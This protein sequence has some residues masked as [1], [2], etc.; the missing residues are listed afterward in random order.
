MRGSLLALWP[1]LGRELWGPLARRAP[2]DFYCELYRAIVPALRQS[3][4][5]AQLADVLDDPAA[6]RR[7]FR[8][9]KPDA[10]Q[11]EAGLADFLQRLHGVLDELGGEALA[12]AYFNRLAALV[13]TYNLHYELR[14]PCRLYPTLPGLFAGLLAQLREHSASHPSLPT[15][16]RD[17]DDALRDLHDAPSQG[18]IKTCLQKQINL[19][20]AIGRANPY[21]KQFGLAGIC[22]RMPLWPH[23]KVREALKLLYG[24]TCDYP[25][26]RHC[27][28]PASVEGELGMRDMLALCIL[29]VGFTPY[30]S[31]RIDAPALFGCAE[32]S[33][34]GAVAAT[35]VAKMATIEAELATI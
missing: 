10:L 28:K 3:P 1:R 32:V 11:G 13:D 31:E 21:V 29:F 8:A 14:R 18:R 9:L 5:A 20:E 17:F 2:G 16:L 15:L 4:G 7:A 27:G 24:F 6:S 19:L 34:P 23:G 26:I 12:N 33:L 35:N 25:G 22:D 30:L